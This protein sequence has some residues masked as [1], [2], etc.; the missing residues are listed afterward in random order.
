MVNQRL[1]C[2]HDECWIQLDQDRQ[3]L[4]H[5]QNRL[6]GGWFVY[7]LIQPE[8]N[9]AIEGIDIG[10]IANIFCFGIGG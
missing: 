8:P 2:P 10:K 3:F 5:F 7:V 9:V 1:V 6:R 4:R